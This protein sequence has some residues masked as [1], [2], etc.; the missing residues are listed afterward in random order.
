MSIP[1]PSLLTRDPLALNP[2]EP[3]PDEIQRL[4]QYL[5]QSALD[6]LETIASDPDVAVHQTR[7]RLKELRALLRIVRHSLG[8][9]I[10]RTENS[11]LRDAGR[12]LSHA[13]DSAVLATLFDQHFTEFGKEHSLH[14]LQSVRESLQEEHQ[15][16]IST[17]LMSRSVQHVQDELRQTKGAIKTW[18]LHRKDFLLLSKSIR[19][20][21]CRGLKRLHCGRIAPTGENLHEWR[22]QVKYHWYHIRMIAPAW[23]SVLNGLAT[24]L[25]DLSDILG[26]DHDLSV[27]AH[28]LSTSSSIQPA[29]LNDLISWVSQEQYQ[30][31]REAWSLGAKLYAEKP[32]AFAMR[33]RTYW[34]S[35]IRQYK[36]L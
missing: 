8:H 3:L 17:L 1:N 23:P 21:Y 13:R 10:Y 22:K 18:P 32:K 19:R 36:V 4:G 16:A 29:L 7:K 35:A 30:L 33:T 26:D 24:S 15:K 11:R 9:Q 6:Q 34:I 12:L 2:S 27:L 5:I 31:R 28:K 20:V 14:T 25:H